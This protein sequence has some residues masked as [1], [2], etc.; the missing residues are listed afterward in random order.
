MR[1]KWPPGERNYSDTT[2]VDDGG[3]NFDEGFRLGAEWMQKLCIEAVDKSVGNL[4]D[5]RVA[6]AVIRDLPSRK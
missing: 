1:H 6:I 5:R 2:P 4:M 3:K